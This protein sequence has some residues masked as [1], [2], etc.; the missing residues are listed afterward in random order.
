MA[1]L[2]KIRD[3]SCQ[4]LV[5]LILSVHAIHSFQLT[6]SYS[7]QSKATE[8][9][10]KVESEQVEKKTVPPPTT[11]HDVVDGPEAVEFTRR[12]VSESSPH[13]N[14]LPL[15]ANDKSNANRSLAASR[16][17]G[18]IREVKEHRVVSREDTL[19]LTEVEDV[20]HLGAFSDA[21]STR[22]TFARNINF[23]FRLSRL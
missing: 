18:L 19:E 9:T 22:K 11:S 1:K 6:L 8:D 7:S 20:K 2:L 5:S 4:Q 13:R 3:L 14:L 15:S 23:L 10:D 17:D 21:V 12:N 16:D